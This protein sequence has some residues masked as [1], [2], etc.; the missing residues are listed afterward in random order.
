MKTRDL[1]AG[2]SVMITPH[3]DVWLVSLTTDDLKSVSMQ[4]YLELP[5]AVEAVY[6]WLL[7][8]SD[9]T[10]IVPD[11]CGAAQI[12][13]EA[14]A[15]NALGEEMALPANIDEVVVRDELRAWFEREMK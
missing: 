15:R 10:E 7:M 6:E 8:L 1:F 11:A 3:D 5:E 12:L 13:M 9:E 4:T 2:C 14:L